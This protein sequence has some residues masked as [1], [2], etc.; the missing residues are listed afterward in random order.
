M[1]SSIGKLFL[2][3]CWFGL[4]SFSV[5]AQDWSNDFAAID[6]RARKSPRQ[7]HQNLPALTSYLCE[8]TESELEKVRAIYVWITTHIAYDWKA[9]EEDKR[10]N[11]FIRDILQREA[12][13]CVGY[14][15]L[16]QQMC[17]LAN[18]RC[19]I[20]SGY[21]KGTTGVQLPL[22]EPNHSWNAVAIDGKWYLLDATWGSS[23]INKANDFV[24][25]SNDDY[26]LIPPD[27]FIRTHLPGNPIWQLLP[28]TV[29]VQDF[30]GTLPDGVIAPPPDTSF[31][32]PDSLARYFSMSLPRQNLYN[33]EQTHAFYPT[34][35][36]QQQLGHALI[37]YAGILS[38]TL[39]QLP[40]DTDLEEILAMHEAIIHLCQRAR[41]LVKLYPW[42]QELFV[43][44]LINQA[45]L[46]YN[47]QDDSEATITASNE[48]I[49]ARLEEAQ[50]IL[51]N[52]EASYF[53]RM[54]QQQC[55]QYLEVVKGNMKE[56]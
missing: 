21:A 53:N 4:A 51:T 31:S 9:I 8:E 52:G 26:F 56:K 40:A 1:Y 6:Q 14:A 30:M 48:T 17:R 25:I 54:A 49:I 20:I 13:L 24:L 3:C 41:S 33:Y 46:M 16:F 47:H 18:L 10:I 7:L 11:H 39:E 22:D 23:T 37:D 45:V 32:Y 42:Q 34:L 15:Q 44:V 28:Q 19:E 35:K 43:N 38:D 55:R 5:Q 12:A 50:D 2:L 36:N 29:S 27:Q